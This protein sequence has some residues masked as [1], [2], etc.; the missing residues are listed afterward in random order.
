MD[1]TIKDNES[2]IKLLRSE[3]V[4]QLKN[5]PWTPCYNGFRNK[6]FEFEKVDS[7]TWYVIIQYNGGSSTSGRLS[8]KE[9]MP[10]WWFLVLKFFY[11]NKRLKN[12]KADNRKKELAAYSNRFFESNKE[13]KRDNRLNEI[14]DK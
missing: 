8:L 9:F 14:L 1:N 5:S 12:F 4:Q 7:E 10:V 6:Y 2:K 11:V 3:M 13:L